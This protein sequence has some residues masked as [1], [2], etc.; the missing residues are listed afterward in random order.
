MEINVILRR[1]RRPE[2]RG[3]VGNSGQR[4]F[5]SDYRKLPLTQASHT[6]H[7][8]WTDGQATTYSCLD[9]VRDQG[10]KGPIQTTTYVRKS[11]L[12]VARTPCPGK[13]PQGATGGSD[14]RQAFDIRGLVMVPEQQLS[15]LSL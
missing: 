11:G 4:I 9:A 13:R 8:V 12:E 14:S 2:S 6:L 5:R 1:L 10:R 15:R 7:I 3:S